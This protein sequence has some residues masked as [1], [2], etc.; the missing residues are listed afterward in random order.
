[1]TGADAVVLLTPWP[2]FRQLDLRRLKQLMRQPVL[3]DAHNFLDDR[4][5]RDAGFLYAGIGLP[6]FVAPPVSALARAR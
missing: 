4:T 3:L 5:A 6:E 1:M 2:E